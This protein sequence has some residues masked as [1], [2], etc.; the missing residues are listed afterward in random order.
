MV[1]HD[2]IRR[3]ALPL[4]RPSDLDPLLERIGSARLVGI[5]E[6]S[7]GTHEFYTW[8]AELTRRLIV[9]KGFG[10]VAVEGDWPDCHMV[11]CSVTAGRGSPTDPLDALQAF[12]R[13]P[14]WMWAN[15]EVL[16]FARWLRAYNDGEP[17]PLRV[18]FHGLDVY[19]L[20]ASLRAVLDYVAEHEPDHLPVAREAVRCFDPYGDDPQ[21]YALASRLVPESCED[22][23]VALLREL[24]SP[25]HARSDCG[26]T[27]DARF[28]AE[29]NVR[30]AADAER[31]YRAMVRGGPESW[32]VRDCHMADTL[33][34]LLE[35][36]SSGDAPAAKAV[37]WEHNIHI[38][39]ARATDMAAAGMVNVG[40]L[41][42]ERH[43]RD[44]SVLIG[45]GTHRGN[46]IA[47]PH[48]GGPVRQ[49]PVP[50]ARAGSLEDLLHEVTD[51]TDAA[52]VLPTGDGH[53]GWS[54]EVRDHRAIGVVYHPDAE[55]R[56][57]YVPTVLDDRYDAF[58]YC[59][60]TSPVRPLHPVE[61]L[62][63]EPETYPTGV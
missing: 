10:F 4:R 40:Q 61:P 18:G 28:V 63:V 58:L 26:G 35:H 56:G 19:S 60:S 62:D 36:Y 43:G 37:L 57:N 38:G 31:Y 14:S 52:F 17:P 55:R 48:W 41:V 16:A 2:D 13:W 30:A 25:D 49:M 47:A 22:E 9:E 53:R 54:H 33:D 29:Q 1:E 6:A 59:D 12:D 45:F 11:H 7:H 34:Q 32:N 46:V 21:S 44:H 39:D 5:G 15:E 24:R 8:R 51:G 42:R 27:L 20:F 50:P 3:A 23:V